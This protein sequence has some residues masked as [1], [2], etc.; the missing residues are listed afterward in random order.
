MNVGAEAVYFTDFSL[1]TA[2]RRRARCED[3]VRGARNEGHPPPAIS[4]ARLC[5]QASTRQDDNLRRTTTFIFFYPRFTAGTDIILPVLL[6]FVAPCHVFGRALLARG[7]ELGPPV[8]PLSRPG[9]PVGHLARAGPRC[10][11]LPSRRKL[12]VLLALATKRPRRP[13]L[14]LT[15]L[16][17]G[18]THSPGCFH[19][20]D[21]VGTRVAGGN[22]LFISNGD[23]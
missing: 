19:V 23:G 21:C 22:F 13:V 20:G 8:D 3:A 16:L 18:H 2:S 7:G 11:G 5:T 17:V 15:S 9:V 6:S 12:L 14:H 10:H 1:A 4:V